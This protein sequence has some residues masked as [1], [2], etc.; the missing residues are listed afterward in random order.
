MKRVQAIVVSLSI[1]GI[2]F[3]VRHRFRKS[4]TNVTNTLKGHLIRC[5]KA[6]QAAKLILAKHGT[7]D[8][9]LSRRVHLRSRKSSRCRNPATRPRDIRFLQTTF[10][11]N[12]PR[13]L[14]E[15][16]ER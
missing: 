5:E 3:A 1:L 8:L 6:M 10:D 4:R 14:H 12:L 15:G 16:H 13:H 2:I 11:G 7:S 9:L